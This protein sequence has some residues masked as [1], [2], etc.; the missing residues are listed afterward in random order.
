MFFLWINGLFN[1]AIIDSSLSHLLPR[2]NHISRCFRNARTLIHWVTSGC[3]LQIEAAVRADCRTHGRFS[4]RSGVTNQLELI[5]RID[6]HL[7]D[8]PIPLPFARRE[9]IY[10]H[11]CMRTYIKSLNIW[12]ERW[13]SGILNAAFEQYTYVY[14]Y[15]SIHALH[16]DRIMILRI[17]QLI[18][19]SSLRQFTL[20]LIE[21]LYDYGQSKR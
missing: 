12:S 6:R 16:R 15:I 10:T 20:R 18:H 7:L 13:D 21:L 17:A 2:D 9:R 11:T 1:Y 19:K 5:N 14:I 4:R 3:S 8:F